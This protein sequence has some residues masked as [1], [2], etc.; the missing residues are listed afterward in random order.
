MRSKKVLMGKMLW[1]KNTGESD[2]VA[3]LSGL[4]MGKKGAAAGAPGASPVPSAQSGEAPKTSAQHATAPTPVAAAAAPPTP[5]AA[6]GLQL[7]ALPSD[8]PL[9]ADDLQEATEKQGENIQSTMDDLATSL[10][11][12]SGGIVF[13]GPYLKGKFGNQMEASVY[14]AASRALFEYW[15]YQDVKKEDA[16]KAVKSGVNPRD[17]GSSFLGIRKSKGIN[18]D[19]SAVDKMTQMSASKSGPRAPGNAEGGVVGRPAPGEFLASVKPGEKIIPVGGGGGGAT[20]VILEL[21]GDMLKQII[22]ATTLN[23]LNEHDRAK[24]SR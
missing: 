16:L 8:K 19:K 24:T 18:D 22:R 20:K 9:S 2:T 6:P 10:H 3:A 4:H 5:A 14:S 23:T 12:S 7:P 11:R 17:F 15:M 13:N 1:S 21:K